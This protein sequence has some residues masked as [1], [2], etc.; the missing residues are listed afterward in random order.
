ML[1]YSIKSTLKSK[2]S[3][4]RYYPRLSTLD[5][6]TRIETRPLKDISETW[7]WWNPLSNYLRGIKVLKI[8]EDI[9]ELPKNGRAIPNLQ[10]IENM[11]TVLGDCIV[12]VTLEPIQVSLLDD[13]LYIFLLDGIPE[14]LDIIDNLYYEY[15][16]KDGFYVRYRIPRC[17]AYIKGFEFYNIMI[18]RTYYSVFEKFSLL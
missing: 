17:G 2:D 8:V 1:T 18:D 12:T 5:W 13:T 4:F 15:K 6:D 16:D 3:L 10:E 14:K 11:F 7:C 9:L